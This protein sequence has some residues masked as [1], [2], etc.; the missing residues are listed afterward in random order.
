MCLR[1][2][3]DLRV[4]VG[5]ADSSGNRK[6]VGYDLDSGVGPANRRIFKYGVSLYLPAYLFLQNF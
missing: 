1:P 3:A 6:T 2:S 5:Q 4:R